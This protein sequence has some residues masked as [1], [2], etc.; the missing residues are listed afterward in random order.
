MSPI[1]H[2]SPTS[3]D[4]PHALV[5]TRKGLSLVWVI[6]LIA[7]LIATGLIY[8]A[9]TEKGPVITIRFK[10]AEGLE[11]G[12]T[13]IKYKDVE[14]GAVETIRLAP[15]LKSILVR[16]QLVK[17]AKPY[18]TDKT[19]FWVVRARLSGGNIS[20]LGT[21]L[22]GNYITLD[23]GSKGKVKT[24]FTGLEIPPVVT[25]DLPGHHFRLTAAHLGSLEYGSP[26]YFKGIKV[27]QVVGYQFTDQ[28][29]D[30]EIK[31]FIDAPYDQ[32]VNTNTRFWLA[33]GL[34][35]VMDAKGIR[36]DT[37]SV[38]SLMIGGL[39][40]ANPAE[41]MK[42][43]QAVEDSEFSLY[44]TFDDAMTRRY[45]KKEYYLLK[46]DNSVRGL[47]IDAPVEF[48][49]F[50]IGRVVDIG[51]EIDWE[52]D[53]IKIPVKVEVE[54]ERIR[55]FI[56]GEELPLNAL[57]RM[58]KMGMRA[59]L[60]TGNLITGN[61]YVGIDF[62]DNSEPT[63]IKMENGIIEIPTQRESLDA[64][65][66]NLTTLLDKLS[67]MPLSEIGTT[68][69]SVIRNL[70]ETS[71]SFKQ[72]GKGLSALVSSDEVTDAVKALNQSM[73]QVRRLT[74]KLEQDLPTAIDSISKKTISA[75][76]GIEE[77]TAADSSTVYE[78]K[79]ALKEFSKAARNISRL[80]DHFERHP[81]SILWGKGKK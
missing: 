12:K 13:K 29:E 7:V 10:S 4:L 76:D 72:V 3:A 32:K 57:E 24:D 71:Q 21:L 51:L 79:L 11:A 66:G 70:D 41:V 75:L 61:K 54:P 42:G 26:I 55:Q 37:Q 33:S 5:E 46:F 30:L 8:K 77:L 80:A 50:P 81:E 15:G 44:D 35:M 18:L 19:Q 31:I 63:V 9:V 23:P 20:G 39:A 60:K 62:F 64:L 17:E 58:V 69:L 56:S 59:Q 34:D 14:I 78:L 36:I 67:R 48:R 65:T 43:D 47:S 73:N 22:S 53:T 38:V 28:A 2:K 25:S 49:G 27:G 40:F 52:S 45:I 68:T 6:P 74:L 16:A 1:E